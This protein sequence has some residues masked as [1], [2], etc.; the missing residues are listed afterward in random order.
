MGA[1]LGTTLDW[2]KMYLH[3]QSYNSK[4]IIPGNYKMVTKKASDRR[5]SSSHLSLLNPI[6]TIKRLTLSIV[7]N[8]MRIHVWGRW[9]FRRRLRLKNHP[10]SLKN[11]LKSLY[12]NLSTHL[13]SLILVHK[14]WWLSRFYQWTQALQMKLNYQYLMKKRNN[15]IAEIEV[16]NSPLINPK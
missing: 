3:T 13:K 15:C 11:K 4:L 8:L 7:M 1:V 2:R 14:N 16:L 6:A 12:Y 10:L 9:A 5:A